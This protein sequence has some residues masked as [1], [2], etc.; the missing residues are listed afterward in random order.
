MKSVDVEFPLDKLT[1]LYKNLHILANIYILQRFYNEMFRVYLSLQL[2]CLCKSAVYVA[3]S[4]QYEAF[5]RVA[6]WVNCALP[7]ER[8]S[9]FLHATTL[10]NTFQH[11]TGFI[12]LYQI[13][14]AKERNRYGVLAC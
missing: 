5:V 8:E 12:P 9:D 4:Y 11:S 13:K 14:S 10:T 1:S 7:F 2:Y 3:S 6:E